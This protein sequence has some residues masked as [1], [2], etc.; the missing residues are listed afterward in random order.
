VTQAQYGKQL[1]RREELYECMHPETRV[2][3]APGKTDGK[4]GKTKNDNLSVLPFAADTA[5]KTG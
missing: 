4:G 2:G 1:K 3:K 5:S